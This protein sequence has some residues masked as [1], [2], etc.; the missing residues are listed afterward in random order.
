M[1]RV[2]QYLADQFDLKE[3]LI[4]YTDG[5][6]NL[7]LVMFLVVLGLGLLVGIGLIVSLIL[8]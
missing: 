5:Y 3:L 8:C 4:G 1:R 6:P 2:K 7:M